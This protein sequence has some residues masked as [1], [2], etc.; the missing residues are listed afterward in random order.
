MQI[1]DVYKVRETSCPD[2]VNALTD[3]G[4]KLIG[5]YTRAF[6]PVGTPGDLTF[7]YVLGISKDILELSEK[8]ASER[9]F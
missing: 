9:R 3:K 6:E 7:F 1:S 2:E 4:W 5:N 8:R